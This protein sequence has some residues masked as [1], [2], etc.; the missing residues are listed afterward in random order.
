MLVEWSVVRRSLVVVA[1]TAVAATAVLVVPASGKAKTASVTVTDSLFI[2]DKLTVRTGTKVTWK[3]EN[4]FQD[5]NVT[6]KSGPA[7]F[8]S[9]TKKSGSFS[10]LLT[11]PGTYKI[12]CTIHAA[13]GMKMTITVKR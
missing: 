13:I 12:V 1:L 5:H 10:K 8:H 11:K 7:K 4:A 9:T 3:W 6:V 2:K